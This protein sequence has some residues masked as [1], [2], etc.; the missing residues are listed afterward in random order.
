MSCK[1]YLC[2][3]SQ[4]KLNRSLHKSRIFFFCIICLFPL[5][6]Y[7]CR[8]NFFLLSVNYSIS[9]LWL[10]IFFSH[11]NYHE[12]LFFH[13]DEW[14]RR[15]KNKL[16]LITFR[17]LLRLLHIIIIHSLFVIENVTDSSSSICT[18]HQ[19]IYPD[20]LPHHNYSIIANNMQLELIKK[21]IQIHSTDTN[22]HFSCLNTNFHFS[23][24][25]I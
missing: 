22:F 16:L 18:D 11:H 14:D 23:C 8:L 2:F 13:L 5:S 6:L 17:I 7:I 4:S 12:W 19:T 20:L 10:W 24:L 25:K 21:A 3:I 1:S 15:L 9:F